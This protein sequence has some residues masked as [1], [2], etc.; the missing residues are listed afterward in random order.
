MQTQSW[1]ESLHPR[2]PAGRSDGGKWIS[3]THASP[4]EAKLR[5]KEADKQ[6]D[7]LKYNKE[8]KRWETADGKPVSAFIS[9]RLKLIG[10]KPGYVRVSLNP[11][12][13]A[14]LQARSIDAAGRVQPLYSKT[15]SVASAAEN[16]A[17]LKEFN[18]QLPKLTANIAAGLKAG[19]ESAAA[20]RVIEQTAIRVGSDRETFAKT[21][22]YGASTLLGQH[23]TL[24][25]DNISLNF[26]G[27]SG[28][29][30]ERNFK[31]PELA[32]FI[33]A[34]SLGPNDRVFNTRDSKIRDTMKKMAGSKDFSPKD[35]RTSWGTAK[36]IEAI[37]AAPKPKNEREWTK[38]H[39]SV[40]KHV[41]EFLGN[42]PSV[43]AKYYIDPAVWPDKKGW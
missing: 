14:P 3:F 33:R 39:A 18:G 36:A 8:L 27:K 37:K 15:H 43:A 30:N 6:F 13:E 7:D 10:A 35:Y 5:G 32:S 16:F 24:D 20:L 4:T 29:V 12:F 25:G 40:S 41:S 22:A 19:D 26:V 9:D 42:T 28:K 23:V 2:A 31:D 21:K 11:D 17:R 34:K 38:L 1:N